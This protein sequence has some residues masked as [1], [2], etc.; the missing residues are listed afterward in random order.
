MAEGRYASAWMVAGGAAA[1]YTER[2]CSRMDKVLVT[3]AA[4]RIGANLVKTLLQKGYAVRAFVLPDDPKAAK[5]RGLDAEV[6]FGDLRDADAV[7]RAMEGVQR[8]AH[9]GYIMGRPKGMTRA[10]EFEINIPGTFHMLEAASKRVDAIACFLFAS[11]NATYDA[12]HAKYVP[13]DERH[14]Q[15]PRSWYGSQKVI[16]E[17]MLEGYGREFGLRGTI[18]R[19]GTVPGPDEFFRHWRGRTVA[20]LLHG[21]GSDPTSTLYVRGV[22][23]PWEPV[24]KAVAEG[25]EWIIPR[26]PEGQSWFQD[27]VDV[28][29]TVQGIVCALESDKAIGEAFNVTAPWAA[30]WEETIP[31]IAEKLGQSYAEVTIPNLWAFACDNTKAKRLIGYRPEYDIFQQVDTALAYQA[32]E[33]TGLFPA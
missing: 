2:R 32:G 17:R 14:P 7:D 4:G 5:L 15:E 30:S 18:V 31:Y 33:E 23:R 19:F 1:D 9:L 3:G 21:P 11:T 24:E 16:G 6:F 12:F 13:M 28:R 25:H 10:T 27:V 22:E 20:G 8:I 26:T 29:D